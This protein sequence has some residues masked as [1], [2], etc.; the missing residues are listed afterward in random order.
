VLK[1]GWARCSFGT[2]LCTCCKDREYIVVDKY[3]PSI[4]FVVH[5]GRGSSVW[6]FCDGSGLVWA[7][8]TDRCW[9]WLCCAAVAMSE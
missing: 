4:L 9:L 6:V 3:I 5:S 2:L 8:V 1:V 7:V